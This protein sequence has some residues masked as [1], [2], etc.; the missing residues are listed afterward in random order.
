M[1]RG[2][3]TVVVGALLI[4][5]RTSLGAD[6]WSASYTLEA[7]GNYGRAIQA[8]RPIFK[9]ETKHEL[10]H[11]SWSGTCRSWFEPGK[12]ADESEISGVFEALLDGGFLRH[13][14]SSTISGKP[15]HGEELLAVNGITGRFQSSWID[16]FHMNYA[17]MSQSR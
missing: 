6:E 2:L 16:D 12:L 9:A 8:L 5:C 17:I 7:Q 1:T 10:A 11:L 15:R 14:Y 4:F 3:R 13:S